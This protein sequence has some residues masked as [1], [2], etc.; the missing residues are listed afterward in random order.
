M[1]SQAWPTVPIFSASSSEICILYSSPNALISSTRAS[2]SALRASTNDASRVTW[3]GST[4]SWLTP[5]VL[6]RSKLRSAIS[7]SF[8]GRNGRSG[9][10]V[11]CND[12]VGAGA[13]GSPGKRPRRA[14]DE[15]GG[16]A[17]GRS[18]LRWSRRRRRGGGRGI[19]GRGWAAA[20]RPARSWRSRGVGGLP[21]T[22]VVGV[23]GQRCLQSDGS[24]GHPTVH[25]EHVTGDVGGVGKSEESDG[26]GHLVGG[27]DAAEGHGGGDRPEDGAAEGGGHV[28]V[29]EAG[30]R[31]GDGDA[32]RPNL[33]AE[34][35][36]EA[37]QPRLGGRVVGL[38]GVA[39]HA[40]DARDVDDPAAPRAQ[41]RPQRRPADVER[42]GEVDGDDVVP[43]GVADPHGQVV[44][45]DA[46]VVDDDVEASESLDRPC[47]QPGRGG[48]VG[49]VGAEGDGLA[50]ALA[51][52]G[53]HLVG[54][55]S[56][57]P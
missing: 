7:G 17:G 57:G 22:G 26:R 41:H 33:A 8:F 46:G 37:D 12:S 25:V 10:L 4:P 5:I 42:G 45:C 51:E 29:E 15:S 1:Y 3:S 24:R 48:R 32:A 21:G 31:G 13:R 49:E 35:L 50:T 39:G 43:V 30:G 56:A 23:R 2:E 28:R 9:L 11:C 16:R 27:A 36:G 44:P 19:Y 40:G 38:A 14:I 53:S 55:R 52:Q 47:H 6:N 18:R 34:R 20:P 54:R